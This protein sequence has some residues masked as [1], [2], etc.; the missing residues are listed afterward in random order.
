MKIKSLL[1]TA[2]L[3]TAALLLAGHSARAVLL[4]TAGDLFL[5]FHEGAATSYLVNIGSFSLYS[6]QDGASFTVTTGGNIGLDLNTTFGNDWINAG[7]VQWG[8]I[9]T[10]AN[11]VPD[12]NV[13]YASRQ[14]SNPAIKSPSWKTES[15]DG[16]SFYTADIIALSNKYKLDGDATGLS[17]AKA[18][19]QNGGGV[20]S[21]TYSSFT[22]TTTDFQI[23]N[24][25]GTFTLATGTSG[26]VLDLYRL[27]PGFGGTAVHLGSFTINDTGTVTFTAVPEPTTTALI[28]T[29]L[30]VLVVTLR[31]RA[32]RT[33]N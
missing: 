22:A 12:L 4:Y 25:E 2:L 17:S 15:N 20:G 3:G 26:S 29:A 10:P 1:T 31:R 21:G 8:V 16:Q 23:G 14:R 7:T 32:S 11:N 6:Q 28:A 5:G 19:V 18:T 30:F 24:I 33:A 27:D 13:V 9:G